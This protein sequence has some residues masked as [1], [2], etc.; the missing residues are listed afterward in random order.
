MIGLIKE[1]LH[2]RKMTNI[3]KVTV[4]YNGS[5]YIKTEDLFSDKERAIKFFDEMNEI[6]R[7]LPR[8]SLKK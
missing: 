6:Y 3:D 5:F 8:K 1:L 7:K 4:T 2:W